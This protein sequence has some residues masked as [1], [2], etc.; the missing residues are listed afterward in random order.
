MCHNNLLAAFIILG[1]QLLVIMSITWLLKISSS[2]LLYIVPMLLLTTRGSWIMLFVLPYY[3]TLIYGTMK[4]LVL[5]LLTT[6]FEN[7]GNFEYPRS[8]ETN[9]VVLPL[10]ASMFLHGFRLCS[11]LSNYLRVSPRDLPQGW[12][13]MS[14]WGCGTAWASAQDSRHLRCIGT[15]LL[16]RCRIPKS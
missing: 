6:A 5:R 13:I 16:S 11:G 8:A 15:S 14:G 4:L 10:G 7:L 3:V 12:R 9:I 2:H 1:Y